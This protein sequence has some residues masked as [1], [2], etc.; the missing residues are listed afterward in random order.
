M[1]VNGSG[2]NPTLSDEIQKVYFG[3]KEVADMVGLSKSLLIRYCHDFELQIS[4]NAGGQ[5]RY[6]Q[7]DINQIR[8]IIDL[9]DNKGF[10]KTGAKRYLNRGR[11]L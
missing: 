9:L 3:T 11:Q 5:N 1:R 7:E 10:T 8:E 2:H 6:R 4:K